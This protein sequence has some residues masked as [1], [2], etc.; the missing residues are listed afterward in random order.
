MPQTDR[1]AGPC[2]GWTSAV[3]PPALGTALA[4]VSI[5][6][7]ALMM[8]GKLSSAAAPSGPGGTAAP[9]FSLPTRTGEQVSLES[10]A[11]K[12]V[13]VDFWASW[14][15]PCQKSFPWLAQ[16]HQR[17]AD[18]GLVIV[19]I[20]LDKK[21]EAAEVFLRD[22]PVPFLVAFDPAGKSADAYKVAAMPSTY[23][24]SRTGV[25]KQTHVG[26]DPKKAA[27]L[28]EL[29]RKECQP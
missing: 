8:A 15:G 2:L 12:V 22:K 20:D 14:C 5:L 3:R 27:E 25:L 6:L 24:I 26:Y 11:G 1:P 28:E 17:Y 4:R 29:I 16:L 7:M 10:L 21:R 19:A 18:K 9:P 13:L 23:L